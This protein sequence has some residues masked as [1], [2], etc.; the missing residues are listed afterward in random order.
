MRR[1]SSHNFENTIPANCLRPVP[2]HP[3]IGALTDGE[4]NYLGPPDQIL[5]GHV[6]PCAAIIGVIAVVTHH[7]EGTFRHLVDLG[8]VPASVVKAI[9][10]FVTDAVRQG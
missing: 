8:V 5:E 10:R 9:E 6:A 7:E 4:E 3:A 2:E 1:R